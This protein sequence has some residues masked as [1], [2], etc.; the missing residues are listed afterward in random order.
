MPPPLTENQVHVELQNA[1]DHALAQ[2]RRLDPSGHLDALA[3][4]VIAAGH[5]LDLGLLGHEV[6]AG[7]GMFV[8]HAV[9][10]DDLRAL[11][12]AMLDR[13]E[14]IERAER[15]IELHM[16]ERELVG[17]VKRAAG[18]TVDEIDVAAG[19]GLNAGGKP[20]RGECLAGPTAA[21]EA[22]QERH[23]FADGGLGVE[24]ADGS[25]HDILANSL[26]RRF[27]ASP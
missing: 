22:D 23:G 19:H 17:V 10:D 7:A 18:L 11:L 13:C 16:L 5:A 21:H 24:G 25:V 20:Q 26:W 3:L 8:G 4:R 6:A 27:A 1:G 14:V 15:R 2:R 12:H 9:N